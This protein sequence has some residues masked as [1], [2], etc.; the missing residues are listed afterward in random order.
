M[1]IFDCI[2]FSVDKFPFVM[3]L[4]AND[5]GP[6]CIQMITAYY[7]KKIPLLQIKNICGISR[8]GVTTL[9]I[10]ECLKTLGFKSVAVSI[11]ISELQR[12]P[13]PAILHWRK[14]HY[15]VLYKVANNEYYIADPSY[16]KIKLTEKDFI[17]SWLGNGNVSIAIP[18]QATKDWGN[19]VV[20]E[21]SSNTN[22]VKKIFGLFRDIYRQ[23]SRNIAISFVL[24]L[25]SIVLNWSMPIIL[26]KII[27][28]GVLM[29]NI[30]IVWKLM[31]LQLSFFCGYTVSD[32]FSSILLT[33]TNFKESVKYLSEYL[34]KLAR[35]PI[36]FFDSRL[37]TDLIQRMEDQERLQTFLTYKFLDSFFAFINLIVFSTILCYFSGKIFLIFAILSVLSIFWTL[38]FL[39]KRKKLDYNRF[40]IASQSRNNIYELIFGMNEIKINNA[41]DT[42]I[43][44]WSRMQKGM[45]DI[46]LKSLYLNYYQLIGS[47]FVNRIR[48]IFITGF[49][50][51]Y[52]IH[53]NM[54]LGVMMTIGYVLGQLSA[55]ITQMI[56]FTQ[57]FQDAANSL[58]RLN[59]IQ[60][61]KDENDESKKSISTIDSG[62]FIENVSF[63]YI[64]NSSSYIINNLS[65]NIPKGKITA[66]VGTSGSGKTTLIKLLLSFYSPQEGNIFLNGIPLLQINTNSLRNLCGV[67]MQDGYIFSGTIADNIAL[68]EETPDVEKL[69]YAV[70]V[71]C[72]KDFVQDL[73]MGYET[74]IGSSGIDLSGGQK[75]R[76]LIARAVYKNPQIIILD[77]ATS[78]LDAN[79]ER[80]I[81]DNLNSF[82]RGRTV[83]VVAHRLSTVKNAD[84]I[85]VMEDGRIVEEGTHQ[86]LSK[87]KGVY[88]NLVKNQLELGQS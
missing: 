72:L 2:R 16:G 77:E 41:H 32:S 14:D 80:A 82:F 86:E 12:M 88:F 45:N 1:K 11:S 75:Q 79:N 85:V 63:K 53:E 34:Y 40:Y 65:F 64:K 36:S 9:D 58:S 42:R 28:K 15:V 6:T 69:E 21:D 71:A 57:T 33:K 29:Q 19:F 46:T 50:A 17:Q 76:L 10:I 31:I 30:G 27:D 20:D 44:I 68:H 26:Q 51:Y 73:P 78:S 23:N 22:N 74:P 83:I 7:G 62:F 60:Q 48:D 35:L 61:Q 5:C 54:T 59:E 47:S 66:I 52:V 18:M 81:I 49:C 37:N 87:S 13:L 70:E 56:Q 3:Q 39:Q 55:P 25:I 67:V 24:L 43:S 4:E 84:N 8:I 38:L